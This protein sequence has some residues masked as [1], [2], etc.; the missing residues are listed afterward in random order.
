MVCM[1]H[2]HASR[3]TFDNCEIPG[4]IGFIKRNENLFPSP[5]AGLSKMNPSPL[6]PLPAKGEKKE[7][8]CVF[9][10]RVETCRG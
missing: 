7:C 2:K 1:L 6:V 3:V 8:T 10:E 5:H 4:S 9:V